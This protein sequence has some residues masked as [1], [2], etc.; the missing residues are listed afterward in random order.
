MKIETTIG[1]GNYQVELF[2]DGINAGW[3]LSILLQ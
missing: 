2:K 3:M 1:E